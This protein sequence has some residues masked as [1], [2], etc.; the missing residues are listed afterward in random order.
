M[1]T[2]TLTNKRAKPWMAQG[3]NKPGNPRVKFRVCDRDYQDVAFVE[4]AAGTLDGREVAVLMASAPRLR[5]ALAGMIRAAQRGKAT[6]DCPEF[7]AA[8][9]AIQASRGSASG[10]V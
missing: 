9:S 1:A 5:D 7:A 3:W 4:S 10:K 2:K 6:V 8:V